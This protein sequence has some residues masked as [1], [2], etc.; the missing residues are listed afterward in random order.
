MPCYIGF[1][2]WEIEFE[3]NKKC[4]CMALCNLNY[5]KW[6]WSLYCKQCE[7]VTP[8]SSA[9][10]MSSVHVVLAH[11][12]LHCYSKIAST[13]WDGFF[14]VNLIVYLCSTLHGNVTKIT[15]LG[16]QASFVLIFVYFLHLTRLDMN[17]TMSVLCWCVD[18]MMCSRVLHWFLNLGDLLKGALVFLDDINPFLSPRGPHVSPQK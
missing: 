10:P 3:I 15:F 9:F 18:I 8:P 11:T 16:P 17:P 5:Y 1:L 7:I 13:C 6:H 12:R 14:L 2:W 4:S